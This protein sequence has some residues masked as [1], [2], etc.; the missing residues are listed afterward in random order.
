MSHA[1]KTKPK[2]KYEAIELPIDWNKQT[3][4]ATWKKK[5][6]EKVARQ[7]KKF[8]GKKMVLYGGGG[9]DFNLVTVKKVNVEPQDVFARKVKGE[10]IHFKEPKKSKTKYN[11]RAILRPEGESKQDNLF[12]EPIYDK[13]GLL[14]GHK[15]KDFEP[16]LGS[17]KLAKIVK[18][19]E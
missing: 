5:D 13:K 14:K 18:K 19:V 8:V 11:V 2:V 17:W 6:A 9:W 12:K 4:M 3:K 16:H 10:W 1:R 15:I 7:Y